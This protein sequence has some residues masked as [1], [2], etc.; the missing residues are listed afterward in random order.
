MDI[1]YDS[2]RVSLVTSTCFVTQT[3]IAGSTEYSWTDDTMCHNRLYNTAELLPVTV[4][5]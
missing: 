5:C 4:I 3:L 2:V 1:Q